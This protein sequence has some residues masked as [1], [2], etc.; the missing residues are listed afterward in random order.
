M[1]TGRIRIYP[2]P[3]A[4]PDLAQVVLA[5]LRTLDDQADVRRPSLATPTVV[6][7][8]ERKAS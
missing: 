1:S 3:K 4:E 8:Q 7:P 6:P 5:L 2:H